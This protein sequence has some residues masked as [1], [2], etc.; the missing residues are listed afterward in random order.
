MYALNVAYRAHVGDGRDF[1]GV[2]LDAAFEYDVSKQLPLWNPKNT[3]FGIQFDV[4]PSEVRE[5][6]GQVRDQ[7]AS[8]SRFDHYV[9]NIDGDGWFWPVDL[10]RLVERVDLVDKALLHA[11]LIGGASVLQTKRYCYVTVRT[12]HGDE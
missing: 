3:F 10:I 2:G 11:P 5:C 8:L 1:F 12:I 7:V 9:I 6:C 4:E